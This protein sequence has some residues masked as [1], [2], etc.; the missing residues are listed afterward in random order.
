MPST[1]FAYHVRL[2]CCLSIARTSRRSLC[3]PDCVITDIRFR[4]VSVISRPCMH[5]LSKFGSVEIRGPGEHRNHPML[6]P[7]ATVNS[8]KGLHVS[9]GSSKSSSPVEICK[10]RELR[11]F[12][13]GEW[14]LHKDI[15][16]EFPQGWKAAFQGV[17]NIE[18]RESIKK[19]TDF[20]TGRLRSCCDRCLEWH[21]T[22]LVASPKHKISMGFS[23]A[24]SCSWFFDRDISLSDFLSVLFEIAHVNP[25]AQTRRGDA[26]DENSF[27]SFRKARGVT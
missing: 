13:I 8:R 7:H 11:D 1:A 3:F 12:F 18:A 10:M 9:S 6:P 21:G 16:Y 19:S 25:K 4:R 17:A 14:H 23:G 2:S 22:N 20:Q 15:S 27:R 24:S 26:S 5:L